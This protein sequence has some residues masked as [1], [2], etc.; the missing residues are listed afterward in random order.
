MISTMGSTM[1]Y[2]AFGL[3][4]KS[5]IKFQELFENMISNDHDTD[6]ADV[7]IVKTNS[8]EQP[9]LTKNWLFEEKRV[10][11]KIENIAIFAIEE[12]NKIT[13]YPLDDYNERIVKLYILGTCV[14]VLLFQRNILPL[15][16]SAIAI[17]G[18]AYLFIGEQGAGKSTLAA[19][20]IKNG[21]QL[22][23]DDVIPI[24]INDEL[25][26]MVLPAYP[27]Q[28]LWDDALSN[29]GKNPAD[30]Q[31]IYG[32]EKKYCVPV[33]DKFCYDPMPLGGIFELRK[34]DKEQLTIDSINGLQCLN[35]LSMHTYRNQLLNKMGLINWHFRCITQLVNNISVSQIKRPEGIFTAELIKSEVISTIFK[36][37]EIYNEC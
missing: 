30:F 5:N 8:H 36:E 29:I 3:K 12:G 25:V 35:I 17:D 15:H 20:F 32:R 9:L 33:V 31:S 34:T 18:K 2:I 26:P 13:V 27:Q 19:T 23:S 16:G 21:Y 22:I 6:A 4:I 10:L 14:G 37:K 24:S 28:K 1:N 11:F 7:M